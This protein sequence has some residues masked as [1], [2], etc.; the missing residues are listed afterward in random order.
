MGPIMASGQIDALFSFQGIIFGI[1][2][3]FSRVALRSLHCVG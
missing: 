2:L 1:F 3:A